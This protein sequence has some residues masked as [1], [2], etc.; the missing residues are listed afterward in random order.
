VKLLRKVSA[1]GSTFLAPSKSIQKPRKVDVLIY[2]KEGSDI[3]IP[4]FQRYEYAILNVRGET[5][6][7]YCLLKCLF[8]KNFWTESSFETYVFC[9]INIVSPKL[10][11]TFIDNDFRFYKI[12][13]NCPSAKTLFIQNGRR[14]MLNDVF[15]KIQRREDF[16]VD[17]MLVAGEAIGKKY[18]EFIDGRVI[19]IGSLRN[20]QVENSSTVEEGKILFISSWSEKPKQG[21]PFRT[22]IDGTTVSWDDYFNIEEKVLNFLDYWCAQNNKVLQVCARESGTLNGEEEYYAKRLGSCTWEFLTRHGNSSTYDYLSKSHIVVFIDS[23]VGYEALSRG[24]R[25]AGFV[26]RVI[27]KPH[28][29]ERFGWPAD[30]PDSGSFWS[31]ESS[32]KEFER[33]MDYLNSIGDREWAAECQGLIPQLMVFD[34]G[35]KRLKELLNELLPSRD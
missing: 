11:V 5:I 34:E 13:A 32:E 25:T 3:L 17:Y 26:C 23:T 31:S 22:L 12:A 19:P 24:K 10:V 21:L 20:N 29:S 30:L 18:R 33:I 15:E 16:K 9:Y 28:K 35:N 6:N 2:D 14:A 8:K 1:F 4:F 27:G 7:L